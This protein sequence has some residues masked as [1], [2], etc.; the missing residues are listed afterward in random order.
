MENK[1]KYIHDEII[2]NYTAANIIVPK[3]LELLKLNSVVDVGCGLATWL[4]VFQDNNVAT[5][6]GVDGHFVDRKLLKIANEDF[7]EHDLELPLVLNKKFD[8][9][10]SL[11]VAEHLKFESADIFV[12]SLVSAS[13][14]IVFS[15][16]IENQGGQNHINE[17]WPNYWIEKF[18]NQGYYCLDIVR[19]MFWDD[20][21]VEC[22]YKQN[23]LL[24]TN[25]SEHIEKFKNFNSFQGNSIV[26]PELFNLKI[27]DLV[28]L[29]RNKRN[30]E[31]GKK[32]IKFYL[33]LLQRAFYRSL[34]IDK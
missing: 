28:L 22:W 9:A 31:L 1:T 11:E 25:K 8:L 20:K 33:K 18:Q 34:K 24:F 27:N 4:K 13:D 15:A 17:Q 5:I 32:G 30:T 12:Q 21:D 14:T 3:L 16:A 10:L 26:H 19:P 6:L 2:H 7:L 23:I 29:E